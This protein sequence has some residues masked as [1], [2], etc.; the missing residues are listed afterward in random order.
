MVQLYQRSNL[1]SSRTKDGDRDA[2]EI[3]AVII[4]AGELRRSFKCIEEVFIEVAGVCPAWRS[5]SHAPT[6]SAG[7]CPQRF[8]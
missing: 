3:E 8:H 1:I 7:Y 6:F 2:R 4:E 5:C